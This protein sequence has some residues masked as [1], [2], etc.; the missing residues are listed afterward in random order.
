MKNKII[1]VLF[2]VLA[3]ASANAAPT[4]Y[5][6]GLSYLDTEAEFTDKDDGDSGLE[7]R[8]GYSV[9]EFFAVEAAYLDLG[10]WDLPNIPDAGGR[11]ETDGYAITALGTYPI[12]EFALIGKLGSFWSESDG[13]LGSVNGPVNFSDDASN[14]LWGAGVSYS[15]NDTFEVKVEYTEADDFEW[16]SLGLNFRF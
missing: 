8:F 15:I 5:Y 7:A 2:S 11:I 3:A 9:N 16:S 13:F 10:T 1:V 14:L 4:G 6:L 12:N